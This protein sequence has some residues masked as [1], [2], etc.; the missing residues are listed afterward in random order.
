MGNVPLHLKHQQHLTSISRHLAAISLQIKLENQAGFTSLNKLLEMHLLPA[1]KVIFDLPDLVPCQGVNTAGIDLIDPVKSIGVQITTD[2]SAQKVLHTLEKAAEPQEGHLL[3][4]LRIV[5]L[6]DHTPAFRSATLG[7]IKAVVGTKLEFDIDTDLIGSHGALFQRIS[8]LDPAKIAIIA[9][10]LSDTEAGVPGSLHSNLRQASQDVLNYECDSGKYIPALYTQRSPGPKQAM[11]L[12]S[13]PVKFLNREVEPFNNRAS[14]AFTKSLKDSGIQIRGLDIPLIPIVR[15]IEALVEAKNE[16]V[17]ALEKSEQLLEKFRDDIYHNFDQLISDDSR[18]YLAEAR[19]FN[20]S[21][22]AL[23]LQRR[24]S[25]MADSITKSGCQVMVFLGKAGTGKTNLFCDFIETFAFRTHPLTLYLTGRALGQSQG[26]IQSYIARAIRCSDPERALHILQIAAESA[27]DLM[28]I[29][30]DGLNDHPNLSMISG[31]MCGLLTQLRRFPRVRL[32]IS[33][34]S[35]FF[36]ERFGGV[37]RQVPEGSLHIVDMNNLRYERSHMTENSDDLIDKYY[38]YFKVNG[39][40]VSMTAEA[41]LVNDPLMLRFFCEVVGGRGKGHNYQ[42]PRISNIYREDIFRRYLTAKL[43]RL[44][45][46][47]PGL[48]DPHFFLG[49]AVFKRAIMSIVRHMV[50]NSICADVPLRSFDGTEFQAIMALLDEDLLLRRDLAS[51]AGLF[52][53]E[54]ETVNFTYDE[55]R[56]FLIASYLREDVFAKSRVSFGHIMERSI[57]ENNP[58]TEGVRRFL[59]LSSRDPSNAEFGAYYSKTKAYQ[60]AYGREILGVPDGWLNETDLTQVRSL[61]SGGG[62]VAVKM[63]TEIFWRWDR[64]DYCKLSLGWLVDLAHEIGTSFY[65]DII[66]P[67]F[68]GFGGLNVEELTEGIASPRRL[69]EARELRHRDLLRFL[70]LLLPI[71]SRTILSG[72]ASDAFTRFIGRVPKLALSLLEELLASRYAPSR[73]M[74]WRLAAQCVNRVRPSARLVQLAIEAGRSEHPVAAQEAVRFLARM[75]SGE[76]K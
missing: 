5:C 43:D 2:S 26:G 72:P 38:S 47:Y 65:G 69:S 58:V 33:C 25:D 75:V 34:R 35:E 28:I 11:R 1:C 18:R 8:V 56:D 7:K 67:A 20:L 59:F 68:D 45:S 50:D 23:G 64:R 71:Q 63:A 31:D 10:I 55:F 15:N 76:E 4:G 73:P 61:L 12:L 29:V 41:Q 40:R 39:A 27:D 19:K 13:K 66:R 42:Q 32:L 57:Q 54:S 62:P 3:K 48:G 44:A 36:E 30:I 60:E 6:A 14:L 37:F 17:S 16:H 52:G 53:T 21:N 24:V 70:L 74:A 9:E 46:A 51:S 22:S 49:S